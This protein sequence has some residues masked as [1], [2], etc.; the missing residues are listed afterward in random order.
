MDIT[1]EEEKR[2]AEQEIETFFRKDV[3]G[4]K[5]NLDEFMNTLLEVL[6]NGHEVAIQLKGYASPRADYEYNLIL[7]NRRVNS[8]ENE[9]KKYR[10]GALKPF[11]KNKQLIIT[12]VSYGEALAPKDISDDLNDEK[13]SIYS[14][15][16]SR[17]RRVEVV[18][19]STDLINEK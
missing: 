11:I 3:K 15:K 12:D 14:V 7:A 5:K 9:L 2:K 8:V 6:Q 16:A 18:K 10:N 17:E 4:G 13:H 1:D 19:I